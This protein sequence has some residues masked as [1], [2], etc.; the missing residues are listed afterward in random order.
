MRVNGTR[1]KVRR[2]LHG[3]ETVELELPAPK[4]LPPVEGPRLHALVSR[5]DFL[6]IDKPAGI[7]VEPEPGQVS[8]LQLAATQFEGFD[9]GG[10]AAPG[11]VHRLDKGTTGCLL[12]AKSDEAQA[13]L[14]QAFEQRDVHKIYLAVVRGSPPDEGRL[15]T[16][17]GRDPRAPGRFTTR[18]ASPRRA[19]LSYRVEERYRAATLL[20]VTL[21]TGRTHQIRVQL[22]EAGFPLLGDEMYG[23]RDPLL[24]RP[25]LHAARLS[26]AG[27]DPPVECRAPL[28]DDL[29]RA[30][31]AWRA[32]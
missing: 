12:L 27:V 16:P 32:Q 6:V 13:R 2:R 24:A 23:V 19:R 20:E 21:E 9:V 11:I 3:G 29:E 31:A 5:E 26:V 18:A 14:T 28:P 8:I 10:V 7:V 22:S 1:A 30:L 17:Y 4:R 25:A 15:D